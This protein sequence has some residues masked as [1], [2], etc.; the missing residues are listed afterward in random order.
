MIEK[1]AEGLYKVIVYLPRDASGK[2]PRI[3]RR[4]HGSREDARR[5]EV[6]LLSKRDR[7]KLRSRPGRLGE[8]L[9]RYVE[10]RRH[11]LAASTVASYSYLFDTYVVPRLGDMRL[12][13]V[14]PLHL[15]ELYAVLLDTG[16]SGT[17]VNAVHR[18][19]HVALRRAAI[20]GLIAA[21]PAD[22]V[23]PPKKDTREARAL[24]K[25]E[26]R[27]LLRSLEG[28]PV[29][30]PAMLALSTGMRRC[31]LLALKWDDIEGDAIRIRKSKTERGRRTVHIGAG[32]QAALRRH[33]AAQNECRLRCGERW[34][35]E[36]YVFPST[37][38]SPQLF[39]GRHWTPAAFSHCWRRHAPAGL[40]FHTLRHT[41]ITELLRGGVRAEVV[42]RIAG[43]SSSAVTMAVYSHVGQDETA[44]M[45]DV[46][47][48]A[49]GGAS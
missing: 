15:R 13:R 3:S 26:A 38:P 25:D 23:R 41:A 24:T 31:E 6:Q 32:M 29:H 34:R 45:A 28:T 40:R 37:K 43:H 8:Y 14:E 19:L 17:T 42:S 16:L 1:L 44:V 33:R 35:D 12:D 21:N 39:A 36:G 49:N 9:G 7:G 5:M 47:K 48:Y 22:L 27:E 46:L 18:F 30:V 20:D 4:V 11:E 2:Y 10:S